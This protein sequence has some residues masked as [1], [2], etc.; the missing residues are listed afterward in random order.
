MD[1]FN[2]RYN[3]STSWKE[4]TNR[5]DPNFLE[6]KKSMDT[7]ICAVERILKKVDILCVLIGISPSFYPVEYWDIGLKY[8]IKGL[9][10]LGLN[11]L[12]LL[13]RN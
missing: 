3:A 9:D 11:T 2:N 13:G 1:Y 8:L 6:Q 5:H 4:N 12:E 10:K 7:L